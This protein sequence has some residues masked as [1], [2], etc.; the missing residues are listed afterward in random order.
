LVGALALK[1]LSGFAMRLARSSP[2]PVEVIF[3]DARCLKTLELA[4]DLGFVSAIFDG[5]FLPFEENVRMTCKAAQMAAKANVCIGG[6]IGAF[7]DFGEGDSDNGLFEGLA[8]RFV[9]ETG[10]DSL[11]LSLPSEAARNGRYSINTNRVERLRNSIPAGLT[12]HDAALLCAADVQQAISA[13]VTRLFFSNR[14]RMAGSTALRFHAPSQAGFGTA[15]RQLIRLIDKCRSG[16]L[17]PL[18]RAESV[19]D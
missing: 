19:G 9:A 17:P 1:N 11:V 16:T 2:V 13:G 14:L 8:S 6:G 7:G 12:L 18:A 5:S 15:V 10:I 3:G 4:L